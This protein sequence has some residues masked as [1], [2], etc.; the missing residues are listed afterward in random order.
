[1]NN[2]FDYSDLRRIVIEAG[3]LLTVGILVGLTLHAGL[4]GRALRGE[5]SAPVP[6]R[7]VPD[8][9][10]AGY[11]V[12]VDLATLQAEI[13]AGALLVD[14][15]IAESY[16]E[17]HLPGSVSLPLADAETGL[18][19]FRDRVPA[20]RPLVTY[21]NGHGCPDSFDLAVM[22][23]EAGFHRVMVFEGG[24]PEWQ[25]AGLPLEGGP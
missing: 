16:A 20:T 4:V 18:P 17:G 5:L 19:G 6:V 7:Q 9:P 3:I 15:R 14:A 22:L 1:M 2:L 10:D 24:V 21:C 13:A 25:A 8:R 12:P 11:P 23:R